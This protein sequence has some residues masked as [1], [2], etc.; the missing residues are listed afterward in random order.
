MLI[1]YLY[2][3]LKCQSH[4]TDI[5]QY[6]YQHW[7]RYC[8]YLALWAHQEETHTKKTKQQNHFNV[9]IN[10]NKSCEKTFID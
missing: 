1:Q 8:G 9:Q 6:Q 4:S 7:Y 3:T 2:K 5:D 10:V